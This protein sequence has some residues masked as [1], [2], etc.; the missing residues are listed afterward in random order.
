MAEARC[1]WCQQ[2]FVLGPILGL[3]AWTCPTPAC[4]A[5]TAPHVLTRKE[6]QTERAIYVPLPKQV[7]LIEAVNSAQY[8]W[9]LYGGAAAGSKSHGIRWLLYRLCLLHPGFRCLLLRRTYPELEKTHMREAALEAPLFGAKA[10]LSGAPPVIEF[11]RDSLLEFGHCQDEKS[12]SSY[13]SAEYALIAFD[14]LVTFEERMV[15]LL[16]SRCRVKRGSGL[17]P[18]IVAGTNP[19]GVNGLWVKERWLDKTV[20]PLKYPH[21]TPDLYHYIPALLDD[22]PY[23][24]ESYEEFLQG[25]DPE[26]RRAYRYGDWNVFEGQYFKEFRL[27]AHVQHLDIPADLP[28][29]GGLDWGYAQPGV[30]LWA[31]ALPDG[32]LHIEQEYRFSETVVQEV[33]AEI[34]RRGPTTITYADPSMWIRTGQAGE[35]LAESMLALGVPLQRSNHERVNGWQRLRAWLRMDS[36]GTP[37]LTISPECSYLIK[38]LPSLV[39]DDHRLEDLDTTGPDHAADAL[40]YLLM[41]RPAPYL[42][43]AVPPL[44]PDAIGH[45]FRALQQPAVLGQHNVRA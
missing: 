40:R 33:A 39:Y 8:K 17:H 36:Q 25:L 7:E 16:A 4:W 9:I 38:T 15:M 24:D 42:T 6:R 12:V 5:R 19:G 14:E 11:P 23:V 35:S 1:C 31:V 28:R 10:L 2:P 3:D 45:L 13:L 20:D 41:G 43:P 34:T 29:L 27:E 30:H 18:M 22:N 21:Y 37:R 44:S 26:R 32:H